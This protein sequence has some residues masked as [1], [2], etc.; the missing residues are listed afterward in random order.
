MRYKHVIK[1]CL[2]HERHYKCITHQ[3]VYF[4]EKYVTLNYDVYHR[5]YDVGLRRS[6]VHGVIK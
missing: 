5:S 4:K 2:V 3:V 1:P 6:C